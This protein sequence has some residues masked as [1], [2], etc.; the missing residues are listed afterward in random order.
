MHHLNSSQM[1][2][3]AQQKRHFFS[4][5]KF[6]KIYPFNHQ[7]PIN[8]LYFMNK[9]WMRWMAVHAALHCSDLLRNRKNYRLHSIYQFNCSVDL[10]IKS[11]WNFNQ[12][13]ILSSSRMV[14]WLLTFLVN[15]FK[16]WKT[17]CDAL[18][19]WFFL[20]TANLSEVTYFVRGFKVLPIHI[21]LMIGFISHVNLVIEIQYRVQQY[22]L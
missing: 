2:S 22:K 1:K 15:S 19:E 9:W 3:S 12:L 4:I 7:I 6:Y 11:K 13:R 17:P 10:E 14:S 18:C 8:S 5:S 20:W 16:N 21:L